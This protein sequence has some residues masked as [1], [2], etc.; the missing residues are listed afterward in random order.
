MSRPLSTCSRMKMS[1]IVMAGRRRGLLFPLSRKREKV[2]AG[3]KRRRPGEGSKSREVL[4]KALSRLRKLRSLSHPLPQAGEGKRSAWH[5][6]WLRHVARALR[7]RD[8]FQ[9][10]ALGRHGAER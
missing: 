8:D 5:A 10:V 4:A 9:V 6:C 1:S 3:A 2:D 7:R